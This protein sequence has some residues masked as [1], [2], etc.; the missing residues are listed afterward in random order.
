MEKKIVRLGR[1]FKSDVM[2]SDFAHFS[3]V[4]FKYSAFYVYKIVLCD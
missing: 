4:F 2:L 3:I 1:F